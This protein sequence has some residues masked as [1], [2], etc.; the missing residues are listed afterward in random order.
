MNAKP[1]I[2][3]YV[4][5]Y[6]NADSLSRVIRSILA[7]THAVAEVLVVDDGSR[8][9]SAAVARGL[10]A[11]LVSHP[12][13]L[14]RGAARARAM[15]EAQH[16]FVLCCDG[17][18]PIQETFVEGALR[19]FARDNVAA[20]FGALVQQEPTTV[21]HR[22][23]GRHLFKHCSAYLETHSEYFATYGAVVRKSAVMQVGNYNPGLRDNEDGDLGARLRA[24][25][26]ELIS[27]RNILIFEVATDSVGRVLERD[28]RWR[29]WN[30]G[31]GEDRS[32]GGYLRSALRSVSDMAKEDLRS[33]DFGS[34]P[35]SLLSPHYRF[36]RSR[37]RDCTAA[38]ASTPPG[39]GAPVPPWR[40]GPLRL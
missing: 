35:V 17:T 32:W 38:A 39:S 8:D 28:W 3:A 23:R 15:L 29:R 31:R 25:G 24:G 7:Q 26:Y 10:G 9:G 1:P 16:E 18:K 20:V 13:N 12:V 34:V 6:N 5:C 40:G 19:W 22:W 11:R 2:S 30:G 36:W 33:L 37:W 4:P 14:G 27:D 21:A